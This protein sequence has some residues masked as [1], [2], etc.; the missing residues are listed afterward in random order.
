MN[1][2]EQ[3]AFSRIQGVINVKDPGLHPTQ[4]ELWCQPIG[5]GKKL[6]LQAVLST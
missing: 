6:H 4:I 3:I 1:L 5:I 2:R